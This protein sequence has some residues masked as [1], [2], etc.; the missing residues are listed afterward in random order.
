[1]HVCGNNGWNGYSKNTQLTGPI[2]KTYF[3]G[4][5]QT[6]T[7]MVIVNYLIILTI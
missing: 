7:A 6:M 1:M 5:N 4:A 2:Q 3:N